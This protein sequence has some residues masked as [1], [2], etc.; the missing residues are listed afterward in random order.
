MVITDRGSHFKKNVIKTV[1]AKVQIKHHFVT[2]YCPWANGSVER[3]N[4]TIFRYDEG[5][6]FRFRYPRFFSNSAVYRRLVLVETIRN[7]LGGLCH[8]GQ[9]DEQQG[10]GR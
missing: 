6:R 3:V 1:L 5:I 10:L 4:R 8:L 7:K 2:A 9:H